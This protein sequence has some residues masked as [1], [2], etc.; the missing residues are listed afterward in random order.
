MYVWRSP[1]L[2]TTSFTCTITSR[3]VSG[4]SIH[5]MSSSDDPLLFCRT[6]NWRRTG[7]LG[8]HTHGGPNGVRR[9]NRQCNFSSCR[10]SSSFEKRWTEESVTGRSLQN[11]VDRFLLTDNPSQDH[12]VSFHFFSLTTL[13]SVKSLT[14]IRWGSGEVEGLCRKYITLKGMSSVCWDIKV[15]Y[16]STIGKT[17]TFQEKESVFTTP[18]TRIIG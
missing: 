13:L 9:P 16:F 1:F 14:R 4:T 10:L 7:I 17:F 5:N 12:S 8:D 15:A 6:Y 11:L 2:C 18:G 3:K